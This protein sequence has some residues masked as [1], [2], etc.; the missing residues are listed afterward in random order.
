M[1][2]APQIGTGRVQQAVG[3]SLGEKFEHLFRLLATDQ[4]VVRLF[5]RLIP[6]CRCMIAH[7]TDRR[8]G[9]QAAQLFHELRYL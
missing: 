1:G 7:G 6:K 5:Q 2:R 3:E 4:H 9:V 8:H